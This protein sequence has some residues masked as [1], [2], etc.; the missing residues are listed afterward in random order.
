LLKKFADIV[1]EIS[2]LGSYDSF[3]KNSLSFDEVQKFL[4]EK[5]E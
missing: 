2:K 3:G 4:R 5:E 1:D